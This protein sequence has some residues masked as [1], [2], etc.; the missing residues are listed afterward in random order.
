MKIAGGILAGLLFAM[1]LSGC[2][3]GGDGTPGSDATLACREL[4]IG[5]IE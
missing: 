2:E 5:V 1:L 3:G 4:W